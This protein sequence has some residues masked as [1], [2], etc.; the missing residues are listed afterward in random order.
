MKTNNKERIEVLIRDELEAKYLK[1]GS[2][3]S[4]YLGEESFSILSAYADYRAEKLRNRETCISLPKFILTLA[5]RN[6]HSVEELVN[7]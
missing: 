2:K 7:E 6:I 3:L 5:A 4:L 1:S